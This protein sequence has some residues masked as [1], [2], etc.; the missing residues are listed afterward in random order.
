MKH[1]V[2]N[3]PSEFNTLTESY[4]SHN[5]LIEHTTK[6]TVPREL[7]SLQP[8][9]DLKDVFMAVASS[10]D[11]WKLLGSSDPYSSYPAISLAVGWDGRA[12]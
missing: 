6:R 2:V 4:R 1:R 9:Y 12:R 10:R 8:K 3:E 11:Q 7:S 5:V